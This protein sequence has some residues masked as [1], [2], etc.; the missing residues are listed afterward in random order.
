MVVVGGDCLRGF[1]LHHSVT[2]QKFEQRR[3]K[4]VW[5]GSIYN[6]PKSLGPLFEWR[7]GSRLVSLCFEGLYS[8]LFCKEKDHEGSLDN[9]C[10]SGLVGIAHVLLPNANLASKK[11][12][13]SVTFSYQ[14]PLALGGTK[15]SHF[16]Y[17]AK[18]GSYESQSCHESHS[19]PSKRINSVT[20]RT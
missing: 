10:T 7:K 8:C 14:P 9:L 3:E 4:E 11:K 5:W 20:N 13:G 19:H 2:N 17:E 15:I 1:T 16:D 6:Y 12:K 18:K